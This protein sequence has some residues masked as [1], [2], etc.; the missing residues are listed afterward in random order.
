ML[1]AQKRLFANQSCGQLQKEDTAC[2][3]EARHPVLILHAD[4]FDA[5]TGAWRMDETVVTNID[6]DVREGAF[7]G[8]EED[9]IAWL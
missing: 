4:D 1:Q 5:T 2:A 7:K 6:A 8:V 3:I 9:Q